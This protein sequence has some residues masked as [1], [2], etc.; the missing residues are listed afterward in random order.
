MAKVPLMAFSVR[1]TGRMSTLTVDVRISEHEGD[2][3]A[4]FGHDD[5]HLVKAIVDTGATGSSI[6]EKLA[7]DL[8]L[9]QTGVGFLSGIGVED[10]RCR[11]FTMDV[12]MPNNV[13]IVG[14]KISEVPLLKGGDFLLGMDIL[15]LGDLAIT[16]HPDGS[17]LLSFRIPHGNP[18]DFVEIS[19]QESSRLSAKGM[20][21]QPRTSG[22]RRQRRR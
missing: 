22:S 16:E 13:L 15:S 8:N 3:P 21:N 5:M 1:Y 10:Q 9:T 14:Q 7:R 19:N 6:T 17:T 2:P 11:T 20:R 12:G 4:G 18:I